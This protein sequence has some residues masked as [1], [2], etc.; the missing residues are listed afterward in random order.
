MLSKGDVAADR[1]ECVSALAD[2]EVGSGEVAAACARWRDDAI[3]RRQWH[4]YQLIGDVLRSE[5]LAS[6]AAR[7]SAFLRSLRLRLEAEPVVLAPATPIES[8]SGV[9]PV[10]AAVAMPGGVRRGWFMPS[11]VAAT[12]AAVVVGGAMSLRAPS[13]LAPQ[14]L[15][16]AVPQGS[17]VAADTSEPVLTVANGRLIR[18]ARLDRYLAAHQQ[19]SGGSVVGGH[20]AYLRQ[21][22]ADAPQR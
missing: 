16:V 22:S 20:A 8:P 9:L 19:W 14:P 13:A 21:A 17:P 5:D 10:A 6:T 12:L 11:A 15:A 3:A 7:D 4:E 2:G 1:A 18:D